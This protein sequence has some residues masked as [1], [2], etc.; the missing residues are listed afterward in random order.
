MDKEDKQSLLLWGIVA[1]S[2]VL[3]LYCTLKTLI[4]AGAEFISAFGSILSA[5]ATVYATF[6]AIKLYA[7]WKDP[8]QANFYVNECKNVLDIY[9][10]LHLCQR[11]LNILELELLN[12]ISSEDG[13]GIRNKSDFTEDELERLKTLNNLVDVGIDSLYTKISELQAE[14]I[15]LSALTEDHEFLIQSISLEASLTRSYK[16]P[17]EVDSS[18]DVFEKC[19]KLEIANQNNYLIVQGKELIQKAKE[20]GKI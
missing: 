18:L 2:V 8:H 9:K 10:Q 13:L 7:D 3:L 5:I 14:I 1:Y 11:N 12:L 17:R 6:I 19:K 16:V 15:M 20:W 4:G